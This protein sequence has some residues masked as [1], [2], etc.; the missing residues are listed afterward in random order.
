MSHPPGWSSTNVVRL[1]TSGE[2]RPLAIVIALLMA[3]GYVWRGEDVW[4]PVQHAVFDTYQRA[5]PRQVN[6]Y[7]AIIVAIDD[8]SLAALGQ[9]PWPRTRL[10]QLIDRTRQLGALVVGLDMFMPEADRLSPDVF[11]RDRADLS[12]TLRAELAQLPSNDTILAETLRRAPSVIGRA[13]ASMSPQSSQVLGQTVVQVYPNVSE[14]QIQAYPGHLVSIT[15]IDTAAGGRGYI[16]TT[17][18][19]DG[20]VRTVPVLVRVAEDTAPSFALELLRV[21]IGADWYSI[22][23]SPQGVRGVQVGRAF[24]PTD[25]DG[26][27]R[28]YYSVEDPRRRIS[29]LDVWNGTVN[30][31][32]PANYVAIIGVTSL[33]LSDTVSTPVAALMEGVEVHAQTIEN[34]VSATRLVRLSAAPW[35]ELG[36]LFGLAA[37]LIVLI[38]RV[39]PVVSLVILLGIVAVFV[40][41]SLLGFTQARLLFDPSFPAAGN[42]LLLVVLLTAG[43]AAADRQ[44]REM[45]A[46]LDAERLETAR[47]IGELKAAHDIQLGM[48]PLPGAIE[49]LPDT[50]DFHALLEP[51]E[52]VGGDFYD[53]FMLDAH[54]LCFIIGDVTG[55][56]VPAALFMALSKTLYKSAALRAHMSLHKLMMS[57]NAEIARENSAN[58]FVTL[59]A[60]LLDTRTGALE[61]CRAGH[62]APILLRRGGAPRM[63]DTP[64]GPPLCVLEDFPYVTD[65]M[66]LQAD[67]VLIMVTDGVTEAQD[68]DQTFYGQERTVAFLNAIRQ[69]ETGVLSAAAV[70][71]GLYDNVQSFMH[72]APASDDITIVVIRFIGPVPPVLTLL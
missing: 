65:H 3:A 51:A 53:A 45:K 43:F 15:S 6:D 33:G 52:A 71:Q 47:M 56:G 68:A 24:F 38:P 55:K 31:P 1:L 67:D 41:S 50:L 35:V 8:A 62:A 22:Q 58:L 44:R 9:W 5:F 59:L 17:P 14:S 25:P 11:I 69:G 12:P 64:G 30:T 21:A 57:V 46:A 40:A 39:Q 42:V 19:A 32:L 27:I 28:L 29:A 20:V 63:L 7:P 2:G 66:Q 60:G 4:Q 16:N 37:A 18:D 49:G 13:G 26:R 70:C 54:R 23:G 34:M 72:G 61:L 10:A 48:V 36:A